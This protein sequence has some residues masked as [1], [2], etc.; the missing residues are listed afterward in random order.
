MTSSLTRLPP[1]PLNGYIAMR[2]LGRGASSTVFLYRQCD[3]ARLVAIKI[4]NQA[5]C[6][7]SFAQMQHE[8]DIMQR[9]ADHP[10]MLPLYD[11]GLCQGR[12]YII[13]AY[14]PHGTC[15]KLMRTRSATVDQVLDLGIKTASA[16]QWAHQ[17]HIVHRDIKPSNILLIG[18]RQPALGD[19]GIAADT[20]DRTDTG[21]SLPWA[22]PEV[23]SH[24][25]TG[26]EACDIYSLGA[27]LYALLAGQSPFQ[28][29]YQPTTQQELARLIVDKP[30]PALRRED[31]GMDIERTLATALH[32]DPGQRFHSVT[33]FARAL[34]DLQSRHGY[35]VTPISMPRTPAYGAS[36][37]SERQVLHV[38]ESK[39]QGS[40]S[41]RG[42]VRAPSSSQ[43][44][45]DS[46][47]EAADTASAADATNTAQAAKTANDGAERR[48]SSA[49]HRRI[50]AYIVGAIIIVVSAAVLGFGAAHIDL[51]PSRHT[52]HTPAP[53]DEFAPS[54][55]RDTVL[56]TADAP[57]KAMVRH[58]LHLDER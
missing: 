17:S 56:E 32:K 31:V 10:Y 52:V 7:E 27:T 30:L 15:D 3:P 53:E 46:T 47:Y 2:Q 48:I 34:Q 37:Q 6:Q 20:Y 42:M 35:A 23:V 29:G 58:V 57:R 4:S 50:H 24:R 1:P 19:F 36:Q 43:D 22:A 33:A 44:A 28:H 49:S 55:Q 21:F 18:E 16:L 13:T 40:L 39:R 14:A 12:G 5:L 8:I 41:A 45:K 9:L 51:W 25:S 38:H 54:R 11:A 26:S